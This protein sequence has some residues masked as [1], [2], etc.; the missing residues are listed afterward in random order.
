[1]DIDEVASSKVQIKQ[2]N[3]REEPLEVMKSLIPPPPVTEAQEV[4][5]NTNREELSEAEKKLQREEE[6]YEL[7]DRIYMGQL[8]N[9]E[10]S[11][12]DTNSSTSTYFG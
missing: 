10:E 8:S 9:E 11:N 2:S 5:E 12:T 3:L 1:M 6:K 4:T 7:Y